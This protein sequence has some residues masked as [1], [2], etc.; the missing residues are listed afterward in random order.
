VRR[1]A[2][3]MRDFLREAVFAFIIPRFAALSID[4][5]AAGRSFSASVVLPATSAFLS[6]FIASRKAFFLRILNTCFLID[7]RCA[8][9]ADVVIAMRC[10]LRDKTKKRKSLWKMLGYHYD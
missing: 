6:V 9:F 1:I 7:A 5:Y 10:I 3:T 8:F 4:L 2:A